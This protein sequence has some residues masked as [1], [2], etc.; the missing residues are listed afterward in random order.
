LIDLY[1]REFR[2]IAE[3]IFQTPLKCASDPRIRVNL[4]VQTGNSMRYEAHV[5]SNPVEGLLYATSHPA[6]SGGELVVANSPDVRGTAAIDRDCA[7]IYPTEGHLVLFD[8]RQYPHYVRHLRDANGIRVVAAMN[9]YTSS[10]T[11]ADR[12]SDLNRHLFGED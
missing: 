9:Y 4:N 10:C 11:E 1:Q 5:D 12:P 2:F 3:E 7:T 6:G 8:A